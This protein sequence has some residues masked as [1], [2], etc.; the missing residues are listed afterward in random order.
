MTI[1]PCAPS[2]NS[3]GLAITDPCSM[4]PLLRGAL[5]Q[6]MTGQAR[7]EVR[8]GESTLRFHPANVKELRAEIQRLENICNDNG[9]ANNRGR[10]MG[11]PRRPAGSLGI[12]YG[13]GR[14]R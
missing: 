6:L 9:T 8:H 14:Y 5:M 7:A 4:L 11:T 2:G 10:A 13:L 1:N 12:P 3:A